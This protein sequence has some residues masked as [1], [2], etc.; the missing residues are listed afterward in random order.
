VF[1]SG[2][3]EQLA[4]RLE[5]WLGDDAERDA[6]ARAVRNHVVATYGFERCGDAYLEAFQSVL[7]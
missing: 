3:V 7:P 5:E 2:E 4:S 1:R 6:A